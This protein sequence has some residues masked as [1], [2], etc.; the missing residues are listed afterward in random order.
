MVASVPDETMRI[1]SMDGM[2]FWISSA[3]RT[4]PKQGAP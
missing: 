2:I 3:S 1:I 4:S